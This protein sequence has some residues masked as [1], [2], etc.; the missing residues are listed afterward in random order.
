MA[1]LISRQHALFSVE[2]AYVYMARQ[3]VSEPI[4]ALQFLAWKAGQQE[5][6]WTW[7]WN[8]TPNYTSKGYDELSISM[9]KQ[10]Q[11]YQSHYL[12]VV[13]RNEADTWTFKSLRR[14]MIDWPRNIACS[15][16]RRNEISILQLFRPRVTC[17]VEWN[18]RDLVW[19]KAWN[20]NK[21]FQ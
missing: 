17:A 6:G 12:C 9:L 5:Q 8:A 15:I 16:G 1:C 7:G 13:Q 4:F 2:K 14:G 20:G 11:L 18:A 10:W 3:M 21:S 19:L